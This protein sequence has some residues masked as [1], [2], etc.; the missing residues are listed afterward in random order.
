VPIFILKIPNRLPGDHPVV[1]SLTSN[2][3]SYGM[4][5]SLLLRHGKINIQLLKYDLKLLC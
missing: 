4:A 1:S 2:F 5:F 3:L